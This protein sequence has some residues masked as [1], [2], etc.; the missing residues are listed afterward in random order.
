[1]KKIVYYQCEYC[2][3]KTRNLK[4]FQEHEKTCKDISITQDV[5][6]RR[7]LALLTSY[8]KLGYKVSVV[9]HSQEQCFVTVYHPDFGKFK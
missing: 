2:G 4:K 7:I 1:M 9:Y 3:A 5:A 8:E 6:T